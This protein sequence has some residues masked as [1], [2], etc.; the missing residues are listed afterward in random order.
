[1]NVWGILLRVHIYKVELISSSG[2]IKSILEALITSLEMTERSSK[3]DHFALML[4]KFKLL[5]LVLT[6]L[7]VRSIVWS[8]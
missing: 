2:Q 3:Q 1:M 4:L 7:F 6:H 5:M 8:F